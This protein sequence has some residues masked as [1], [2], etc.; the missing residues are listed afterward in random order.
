MLWLLALF[1]LLWTS[2]HA[3]PR[4]FQG[5]CSSTAVVCDEICLSLSEDSYECGCWSGHALGEDGVSCRGSD[6][7]QQHNAHHSA[8]EKTRRVEIVDDSWMETIK[9]ATPAENLT[10]GTGDAALS[11]DSHNYAHFIAPDSAYLETNVS[12]EFKSDSVED[13]LLF[14]G[15]MYT[16]E[17]FISLAIAG[18]NIVLRYDCGE[19]I[20]TETYFGPFSLHKWH[21]IRVKRKYCTRS[22]ITVDA[23]ATIMDDNDAYKNYKG[24]SMADGFF[25]GGAP[26]DVEFLEEKTTVTRG[27]KGCVRRLAV[28]ELTLLDVGKGINNMLNKEMIKPCTAGNTTWKETNDGM[29]VRKV[30]HHHVE[31][32]VLESTTT[33]ATTTAK[34]QTTTKAP[35]TTVKPQSPH[36]PHNISV[37]FNG[38]LFLEQ[39][40][41]IEIE[42]YIDLEIHFKPKRNKG[43][44]FHWEDH[45]HRLSVFLLDGFVEVDMS[46]GG[47]DRT[48]KSPSP[49]SL[50]SWHSVQ[51]YRSGK[52]ILMKVDKQ[53]FV[54]T[55]VEATDRKRIKAGSTFIGGSNI[56]LPVAIQ[57]VGNY[58]GCMKKI[59]LNSHLLAL[60]HTPKR[61]ADA[62]RELTVPT[63][64]PLCSSD[65]C[66]SKGKCSPNDCAASEDLT[67][68]SCLCPFPSFGER[69]G[70]T[71]S[72]AE[73]AMRLRGDGFLLLKDPAVMEHITG[74]SLKFSME[75]KH[76]G[77]IEKEQILAYAGDLE[78]DDDF[79]QIGLN[80]ERK[81]TVS[82]NLGAGEVQL[83]HSRPLPTGKWTTIDVVRT[84]RSIRITV[85][86]EAPV[87]AEAPAGSEQLNVYDAIYIGGRESHVHLRDDG[88]DGCIEWIKIDDTVITSP[89]QA[90]QSINVQPCHSL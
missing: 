28:N 80:K 32:K 3:E 90:T 56:K 21:S 44:L 23:M 88:F 77:T 52:G 19:G 65:P 11:F 18:G 27:F 83:T 81:V 16:E 46:L 84:K 74:D 41:P 71:F 86:G 69:C 30:D 68:Y 67:K 53:R 45:A 42:Q 48:L 4:V 17:D 31:K 25:L 10:N 73:G 1:V 87:T 58:V 36:P 50:N 43:L 76:N 9:T 38:G 62:D 24:I 22:E 20:S 89:R 49:V 64:M 79:M 70:S 12:I 51:V 66:S 14:F 34:Q 55:E 2:G 35:T 57:T 60:T 47:D 13:G 63:A 26:A 72:M 5:S 59:R 37:E 40:S 33:T 78:E 15:G 8:K 29:I 54:D 75:I 6:S 85:D 39:P 82:M 61:T 7:P